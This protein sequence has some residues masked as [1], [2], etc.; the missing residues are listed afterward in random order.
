[1]PVFFRPSFKT[2]IFSRFLKVTIATSSFMNEVYNGRFAPEFRV[3]ML[4]QII[5]L[6]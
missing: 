4:K 6:A 5:A 2:A 3:S 1:M